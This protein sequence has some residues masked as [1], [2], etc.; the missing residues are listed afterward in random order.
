ME[1]NLLI[2]SYIDALN[3]RNNLAPYQ[4]QGL[5]F[6]YGGHARAI[7]KLVS[8]E[9]RKKTINPYFLLNHDNN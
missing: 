6:F 9:G 5:C 8:T 7:F 2:D 4:M 1:L 3:I